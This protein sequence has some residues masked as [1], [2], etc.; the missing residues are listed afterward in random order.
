MLVGF[1]VDFL[2]QVDFALCGLDQLSATS[3]C[4]RFLVAPAQGAAYLEPAALVGYLADARGA[5][6][7]PDLKR[8]RSRGALPL[9]SRRENV[10]HRFAPAATAL[11]VATSSAVKSV[12]V[13]C[14][15][16]GNSIGK[17]LASISQKHLT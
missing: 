1:R 16:L 2:G 4:S 5:P 10:F 8:Y 15:I 17:K 6:Y 9:Q 14:R 3:A 13:P 11:P 7:H 12:V